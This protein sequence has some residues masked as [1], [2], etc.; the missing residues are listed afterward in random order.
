MLGSAIAPWPTE[1]TAIASSPLNLIQP[2]ISKFR[3]S[4]DSLQ[5]RAKRHVRP[6]QS[7]ER[8]NRV[9]KA[10]SQ[11]PGTAANLQGK[12]HRTASIAR[13]ALLRTDAATTI[14]HM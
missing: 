10:Y 5:A 6:I 4:I 13:L 1:R 2:V 12:F 3:L 7:G 8:L 11:S 9:H 14:C